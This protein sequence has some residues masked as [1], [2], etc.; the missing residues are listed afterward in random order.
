MLVHIKAD[1]TAGNWLFWQ[2]AGILLLGL[3]DLPD[4]QGRARPF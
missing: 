3:A 4:P 1:E 2:H